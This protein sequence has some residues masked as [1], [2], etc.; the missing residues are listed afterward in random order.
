[1]SRGLKLLRGC[2]PI[3]LIP[4]WTLTG[5]TKLLQTE[6]LF[7]YPDT[8]YG[9]MSWWDYG[10]YIET[11]GHRM[12]NANPFQA[13]I[14]G[15]KDSINEENRPGAATFL[16]AQSEDEASAVLEAIDP[17]PDKAGARYIMSDTKMATDIFGAMPEWTLILKGIISLTG[18]EPGIKLCLLLV[19]SIP[20]KQGFIFLTEMA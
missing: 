12:P 17:D 15:R 3:L 18:Q 19:T 1:M 16:T 13:G 4:E 2:V 11:I 10:H 7:K 5:F 6:Q 20:W 9:V 8:A 14:G